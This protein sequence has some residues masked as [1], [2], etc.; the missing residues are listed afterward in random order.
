MKDSDHN[1]DEAQEIVNR[2]RKML[3][4]PQVGA[5]RTIARPAPV[6]TGNEQRGFDFGMLPEHELLKLQKASGEIAGI[7]NPFYRLHDG[8]AAETTSL[9]G[10]EVVNFSSYDYLGLNGHPDI[11]AAAKAAIDRFGTAVSASRLT[12]GERQ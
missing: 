5:E 4:F 8:L 12:A 6:T 10:R 3:T 1:P 7:E 9:D 11:I 2:V